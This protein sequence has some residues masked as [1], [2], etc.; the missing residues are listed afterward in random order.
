MHR[1]EVHDQELGKQEAIS[2]MHLSETFTQID[3]DGDGWVCL[4]EYMGMMEDSKMVADVKQNTGLSENDVKLM[5]DHLAR[6]SEEHEE[7]LISKKDFVE[8]L[9]NEHRPVSER[10]IMRLEKR[11]HD[12]EQ[13]LRKSVG[14]VLQ[15]QETM[16]QKSETHSR[17]SELAEATRSRF[18]N[19]GHRRMTVSSKE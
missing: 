4:K 13:E 19:W 15:K 9:Q 12:V 5:W 1:Q 8:G 7:E 14:S 18:F 11:L 3:K 17:N 2:K 10:S 6:W 16:I